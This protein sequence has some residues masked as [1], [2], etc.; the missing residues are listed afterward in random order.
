MLEGFQ[1]VNSGMTSTKC[2][3]CREP[4]EVLEYQHGVKLV[5]WDC[6]Y[7]TAKSLTYDELAH[8]LTTRLEVRK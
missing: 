2:P 4:L 3:Y 6:D 7:S 8:K 5:C 1:Y